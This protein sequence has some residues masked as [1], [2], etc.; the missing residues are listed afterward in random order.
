MYVE[1]Q[2]GEAQDNIIG[3]VLPTLGKEALVILVS[4]NVTE[5]GSSSGGGFPALLTF[6]GP[7]I[8]KGE[9][10]ERPCTLADIVP[11]ICYLIDFPVPAGTTG[12]VLYQAFADRDFKLKEINRLKEGLARLETAAQ[13]D[14]RQ[15]WD[16]HWPSSNDPRQLF[17]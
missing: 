5:R 10:L 11:T 4:P 3:Q 15:S 16:K 8:R 13:R 7:G 9:Q 6:T 1:S 12:A 17:K 14:G 2:S